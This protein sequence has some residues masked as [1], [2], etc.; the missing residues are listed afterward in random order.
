MRL[1]LCRSL[2]VVPAAFALA[3]GA[4]V[5]P[6][7][8][9]TATAAVRAAVAYERG[10]APT[11][12]G[13]RTPL[14]PFSYS[15]V[16]VTNAEANGFGGGTI[17]YPNDTTQGTFGGVAISPGYTGPEGHV[18]WLGPRLASQGF[19]VFTIATNSVYDQPTERGQQLLAA[20]DHLVGK[21]PAQVRQRLDA[22]RLGVM[23]HSMGGGG[24]M[25]AAWSRSS[26][27][28]AVP[29][30]PYHTIKNWSAIYV[31]TLFF[32]GTEDT[33][34]R[35]EDHAERF[36]SSM[37]YA[38]DRAYAEIAGADHGTFVREHP[39]IGALSVAWL[40]RFIDADT[41]Y[42]QFLCPPP[43]GPELTE[44]RDS[45]PHA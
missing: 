35:P 12:A 20:L 13:I 43:T 2:A 24:A 25:Y 31:P 14:G 19:I 40:K 11:W 22:Q 10:P 30:A 5:V 44:Y 15:K 38:R 1:T 34:T 41:R 18:A 39:L 17:Y 8:S 4:A 29:L 23:G 9:P 7:A 26:L 3:V 42:D 33:V 37:I 21:S 36:Y 45:C 16:T 6:P 28:A 27:K 32:A